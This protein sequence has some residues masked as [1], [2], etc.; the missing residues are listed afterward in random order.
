MVSLFIILL[1][2][3]PGQGISQPNDGLFD[4]VF[5]DLLSFKKHGNS[6][7]LRV[8]FNFLDSFSLYEMVPNS[9]DATLA[10]DPRDRQHYLFLFFNPPA[11]NES[12][13]K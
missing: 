1:L 3:L 7:L 9:I 13:P 2:S 10:M 12:G 5:F 11:S 4:L 8:A 6:F